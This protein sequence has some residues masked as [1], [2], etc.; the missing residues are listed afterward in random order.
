MGAEKDSLECARHRGW[1][2]AFILSVVD[3]NACFGYS[4]RKSSLTEHSLAPHHLDW[5]R[6]G[7]F[8]M[9]KTSEQRWITM[10]G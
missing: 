9:H 1:S 2:T 7:F 3:N 6:E 4:S 5:S 8:G 10:H